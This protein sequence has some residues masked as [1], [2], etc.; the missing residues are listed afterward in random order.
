MVLRAT[1]QGQ[2][3]ESLPPSKPVLGATKWCVFKTT[4]PTRGVVESAVRERMKRMRSQS[5]DLLQ[6]RVILSTLL[7][8][9]IHLPYYGY[10][11]IG[12]ITL[13]KAI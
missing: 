13:I 9:V 2:F 1:T 11:F 7:N 4:V 6:V 10:S 5:V 12:K 3:R 8:N